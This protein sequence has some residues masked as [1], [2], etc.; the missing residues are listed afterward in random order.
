MLREKAEKNWDADHIRTEGITFVTEKRGCNLIITDER[1]AELIN[2]YDANG[3]V[4]IKIE[5]LILLLLE[6]S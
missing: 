2:K 6:I 5:E 4:S 1:I 3:T